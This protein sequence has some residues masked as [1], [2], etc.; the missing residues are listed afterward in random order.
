MQI[1]IDNDAARTEPRRLVVRRAGYQP[2]SILQ[3]PSDENVRIIAQLVAAPSDTA[4]ISATAVGGAVAPGAANAQGAAT[5]APAAKE[6]AAPPSGASR[7]TK[8]PAPRAEPAAPSVPAPAA[9]AVP[10]PPRSSRRLPLLPISVCN[11]EVLISP[12]S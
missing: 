10:T 2:Y 9:P 1:S 5:A 6:H 12:Q 8:A 4:G 7:A 3:G 11:A